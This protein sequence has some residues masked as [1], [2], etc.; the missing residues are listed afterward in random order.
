[1]RKQKRKTRK[2][3]RNEKDLERLSEYKRRQIL[4][5]KF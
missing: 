2:I 3:V 1:M 5:R 4:F